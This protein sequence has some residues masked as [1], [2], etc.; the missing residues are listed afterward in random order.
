MCFW[1][2]KRIEVKNYQ[3][4]KKNKDSYE[5]CNKFH[6]KL[7]SLIFNFLSKKFL[8]QVK[9]QKISIFWKK[10]YFCWKIFDHKNNKMKIR[11]LAS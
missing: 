7:W 9:F 3:R 4:W 1:T 2:F 6:T 11:N 8:F 5:I 10:M